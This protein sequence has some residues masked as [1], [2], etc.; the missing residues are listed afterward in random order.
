VNLA[1]CGQNGPDLVILC[2]WYAV[3]ADFGGGA[4]EKRL[5]HRAQAAVGRLPAALFWGE[6]RCYRSFGWVTSPSG[7]AAEAPGCVQL[8]K[9]G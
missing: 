7:V 5:V 4:R 8:G 6:N 9:I 1:A 3:R 2:L